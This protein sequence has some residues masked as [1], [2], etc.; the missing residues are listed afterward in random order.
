MKYFAL[1]VNKDIM[2]AKILVHDLLIIPFRLS[3]SAVF[4]GVDCTFY[5]HLV[6]GLDT[7]RTCAGTGEKPTLHARSM[8]SVGAH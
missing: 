6:D 3:W 2:L 1:R 4:H 7:D 5:N 8:K